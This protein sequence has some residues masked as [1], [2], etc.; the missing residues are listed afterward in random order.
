VLYHDFP[1][2]YVFTKQNGWRVRKAGF[3]IG[4]MYSATPADTERFHL[5][6]LLTRV[7]GPK[8]F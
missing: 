4:R 3:A 8:S 5:R 6:L 2:K 7:R 1:E